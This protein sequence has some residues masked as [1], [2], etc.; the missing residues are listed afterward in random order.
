[1]KKHILEHFKKVDP[2]LHS[3]AVQVGPI[4]LTS[5]TK[6][7]IELCDAIIS[8]QLSVKAGATIVGRFFDLFPNKTPLPALVLAQPPEKLRAVGMS[9]AKVRYVR[10]LAEAVETGAVDLRSL[11]AISDAEVITV[12]TKVKGIGVWTAEMFLIFSL[13]REDVF[14]A[15]DLGLRRA[16]QKIYSLR[17]E[18]SP[19]KLATLS[20]K[21]APY[22]SYASRI[23]WKSLELK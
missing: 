12:L 8:Q 21:W 22:R 17:S 2:K 5:S 16:I 7:F 4:E 9:N 23:L 18:P 15:G 14:S 1:M 19:K 10:A 20:K 11:D 3:Y 13:G 6:H